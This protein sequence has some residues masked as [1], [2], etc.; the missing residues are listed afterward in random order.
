[1]EKAL[2]A[3]RKVKGSSLVEVLLAVAIFAVISVGLIGAIIYGQES[4]AVAG[5]RERASKIAEEGVEAVRN[6]RDSGYSN[7]P[8][9][10]TYGLSIVGGVWTL[11]GSSDTTDIFTR[12][13]TLSTVD[14]RT[15]NITVNVTWNQTVQRS[16][17]LALNTYLADWTTAA[18]P[19]HRGGLLVYE[20]GPAAD[21]IS[22]K[23]LDS[24][25]NW[26][27]QLQLPDID[28]A[29][30]NKVLRALQVY[31]K[32]GSAEKIA[33][34]R[35]YDGTR[36]YIYAQVWNGTSWGNL[37]HLTSAT[38]GW[39]S[40]AFLDVQ[41]FSGGY[42]SNGSFMML[43]S[44]G[45]TTPKTKIWN[46]TAWSAGTNTAVVTTA[47]VYIIV[48]PQ[49]GTINVM[50]VMTD[51]GNRSLS[52]FW[53]GATWGG[54]VA[55]AAATP[56]N[57]KQLI[58]FEWSPSATTKGAIVYPTATTTRSVTVKIFDQPSST[59]SA[60]ANGGNVG[61]GTNRSSSYGI[62]A[63]PGV[64]VNTF[65]T[66]MKDT[67]P[68]ISCYHVVPNAVVGTAPALT[69]IG[70]YP[71]ISAT[72][73]GIQK[74]FEIAY[75][76]SGVQG[77]IAYSD[78]TATGKYKIYTPGAPGSFGTAQSLGLSAG[79]P[80]RTARVKSNNQ[81]DDLMI[82]MADNLMNLYSVAWNGTTNALYSSAGYAFTNHGT[83][84][85]ANTDYWYDFVWDTQ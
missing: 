84:G 46:G 22:Y 73:S 33:I 62:T 63:R 82:I 48:K 72:E 17:S 40:A 26:S 21:S 34:S 81:D 2:L 70:V 32:P 8:A 60:A 67:T 76:P 24:G 41:N 55:H 54:L 75:E 7:L 56:T 44:D 27:S 80:I 47:P 39:A 77:L 61:T 51:Q 5:A 43:H 31:A 78:N 79:N 45:T 68:N 71:N 11:A 6:I 57:T 35:H 36:Q 9:D 42:L 23:T 85:N 15:R 64:G 1:M 69:T 53:N 49:P 65:T 4:T 29:T 83:N 10:G 12:T 74:S 30:S 16:G 3:I 13:V 59:W 19:V 66:C 20:G 58:D 52:T 28:G 50:A 25:G 38:N 37:I 18:G 14:A